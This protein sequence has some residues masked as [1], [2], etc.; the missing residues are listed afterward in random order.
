MPGG[1]EPMGAPMAID[2][3]VLDRMNRI[4]E[5]LDA[6][7]KFEAAKELVMLALDLA[8][9]EQLAPYLT[10]AAAKR[11]NEEADALEALKFS[12]R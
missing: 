4:F 12:R 5:M 3:L 2:P 9:V 1:A 10:D 6:G 7:Q 8:P 11:G